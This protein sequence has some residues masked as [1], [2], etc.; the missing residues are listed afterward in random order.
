MRIQ[1]RYMVSDIAVGVMSQ[2]TPHAADGTLHAGVLMGFLSVPSDPFAPCEA[3]TTL[4]MPSAFS[5]PTAQV[6]NNTQ[7]LESL[8]LHL[9]AGIAFEHGTNLIPQL[10]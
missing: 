8:L 3:Q 1:A 5:P 4:G 2:F 7:N 10:G 6:K 9:S